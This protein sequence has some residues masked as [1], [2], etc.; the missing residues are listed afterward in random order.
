MTD[1]VV[2]VLVVVDVVGVV[3]A[4]ASSVVVGMT[5]T[6]ISMYICIVSGSPF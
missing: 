5:V 1:S 2:G 6:P 4:V 3:L